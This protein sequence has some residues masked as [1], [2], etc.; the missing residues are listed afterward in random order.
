M[1]NIWPYT[2]KDII[3][4]FSIVRTSNLI[5]GTLR[6]ASIL[7]YT[8]YC[9]GHSL[10]GKNIV[11]YIPHPKFLLTIDIVQPIYT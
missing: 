8:S 3:F 6:A 10:Q 5:H 7:I 9:N 2:P 1:Q 4:K 11:V